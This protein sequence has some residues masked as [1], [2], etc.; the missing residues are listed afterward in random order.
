[1]AA[2]EGNR[3][4][5]SAMWL[6]SAAA[7]LVADAEESLPAW[8]LLGTA[9]RYCENLRM[10]DMLRRAAGIKSVAARREFLRANG[11]EA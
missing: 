10:A 4:T 2:T 7:K 5:V 11:V 9:D 3:L 1:M 6:E 8:I